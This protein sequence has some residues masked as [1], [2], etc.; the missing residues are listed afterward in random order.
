MVRTSDISPYMEKDWGLGDMGHRHW[1]WRD[2]GHGGTWDM[3]GHGMWGDIG[4]VGT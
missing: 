1:T 4:H 3:G 2:M